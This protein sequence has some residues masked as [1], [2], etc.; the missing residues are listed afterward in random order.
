M[1]SYSNQFLN[2]TKASLENNKIKVIKAT[3]SLIELEKYINKKDEV[4]Y[5]GHIQTKDKKKSDEILEFFYKNKLHWICIGADGT[6]NFT[7][8]TKGAMAQI[9][10]KE[11]PSTSEFKGFIKVLIDKIKQSLDIA[12]ILKNETKKQSIEKSFDKIISIGAST[13][14]TEAVQNILTKLKADMPPILVVIHMPAGFT[15][16]YA[17]RLNE[18]CEMR[19]KEA[20]DGDELKSGI[21]YIAPGGYQMRLEKKN[22][23]Y[24]LRC[25]KEEKVNGH[26]P[27]VD[28]LFESV[29]KNIAPNVVA[30]ILTGMGNDG[31]LGI[32]NIKKNGGYTIGQDEKSSV[33]Y[34]M[35]KVANDI[36]GICKQTDLKNIPNIISEKL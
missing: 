8:I 14:G 30:V 12:N 31:A 34:G 7:A 17:N 15:K 5:I 22:K 13:G 21:A 36:G 11:T 16:I 29:A 18:L 26:I 33:V 19:V 23:E 3:N 9:I 28:V 24:F 2:V 25:T 27:S 35:P 32:L 6:I 4:I 10:L 1:F 20:E